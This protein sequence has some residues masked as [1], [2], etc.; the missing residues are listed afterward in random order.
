MITIL[1]ISLGLL[2]FV[3]FEISMGSFKDYDNDKN[4]RDYIEIKEGRDLI[5]NCVKESKEQKIVDCIDSEMFSAACLAEE[6]IS[7][8]INFYSEMSDK[9]VLFLLSDSD[10]KQIKN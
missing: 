1:T 3:T 6:C 4:W 8:G 2:I 5:K 10:S 9:N 7:L